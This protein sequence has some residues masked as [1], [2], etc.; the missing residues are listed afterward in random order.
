M[1]PPTFRLKVETVPSAL[2]SRCPT[3]S[4]WRRRDLDLEVVALL[5]RG[6][7]RGAGALLHVR[8]LLG[9]VVDLRLGVAD[10]LLLQLR[11]V[12]HVLHKGR[13]GCGIRAVLGLRG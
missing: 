5:R 11:V 2:L 3:D 1:L 12:H 6:V 4:A 8:Q 13:E 10:L 7:D 9:E